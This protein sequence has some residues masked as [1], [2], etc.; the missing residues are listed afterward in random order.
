[1]APGHGTRPPSHR[2]NGKLLSGMLLQRKPPP[3]ASAT[4]QIRKP[5][6]CCDKHCAGNVAAL[7]LGVEVSQRM[8]GRL[9][10]LLAVGARFCPLL[11]SGKGAGNFQ[12]IR[13]HLILQQTKAI[14]GD[15][16]D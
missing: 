12:R 4:R 11:E 16:D 2:A 8:H 13:I 5:K 14:L 15:A 9:K 7:Q 6:S 1:M 3:C 10:C